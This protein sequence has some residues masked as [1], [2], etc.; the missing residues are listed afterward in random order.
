MALINSLFRPA[1]VAAALLL[2]AAPLMAEPFANLDTSFDGAIRASGENRNPI[3]AGGTAIITGR[4][5][6]PGQS[7]TLR[8]NGTELGE[9][10]VEVNDEGAFE[11]R[12]EI[13]EGVDAGT[14]PV[15]AEVADPAYATTFEIKVSPV[16]EEIGNY[17]T[18]SQKLASGL[19]QVASGPDAI[20]VTAAVGRPPVKNSKLLKLDPESFEVVAEATPEAAPAREDGSDGGVFAVYGVG[21]VPGAHQVWVTNTRQNTVAAYDANDLSLLKQ[22]EPGLVGHPRDAVAHDGKVYVSATFLPE[23][24]VFDAESLSHEGIIEI[25]SSRRRGEFGTAS[26]D[27]DPETGRLFVASLSSDE[28]AVIDLASQEVVSVYPLQ[29]TKSTI[30]VGYDAKTDRIFAVGQNSDNLMILD[31]KNGEVLHQVMV[32]ANP[33]NV[34]FEPT[35]GVAY[36]ALR[37]SGTVVAVTPEGEVVGNLPVGSLPNHLTLDGKGGVLV[38][39]KAKGAEDATGDHITR[40]TPES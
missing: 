27:I 39:N 3:V 29:G 23:V 31:A 40:I 38:V 12:V 20:Y 5:F 35:A 7:V 1:S 34:T 2:S 22:F 15:V 37:G 36:V 26:L 32:G 16:L 11:A 8:Q 17:A 18:Q 6:E 13:P 24:H 33:L 19:Y 28:V 9:G 10:P 14:Y 21:Y 4:E 30:G 25:S